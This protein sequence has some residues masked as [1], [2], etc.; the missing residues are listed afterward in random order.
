MHDH[1][2]KVHKIEPSHP[3]DPQSEYLHEE[4]TEDDDDD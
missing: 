3:F 2:G 4:D 1:M